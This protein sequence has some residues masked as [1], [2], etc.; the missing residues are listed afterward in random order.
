LF[1]CPALA[2]ELIAQFP[3]LRHELIAQLPV[4]RN[5]F[6]VFSMFLVV[7]KNA[8]FLV[9]IKEAK[10]FFFVFVVRVAELRDAQSAIYPIQRVYKLF[11][12]RTSMV[13][14]LA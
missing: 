7:L 1:A 8:D 10:L 13:A 2:F 12:A 14:R 6:F 3:V 9:C 11:L 5:F 4:L